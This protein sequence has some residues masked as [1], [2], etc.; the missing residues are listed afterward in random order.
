MKKVLIIAGIAAVAYLGYRLYKR[1]MQPKQIVPQPQ[2]T[3]TPETII[4]PITS[5]R[6]SPNPKV[7]NQ[8]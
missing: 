4:S 2:P 3:N 5:T 8:R 7:G 6:P 1:Q